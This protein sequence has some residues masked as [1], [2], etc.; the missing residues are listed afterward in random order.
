MLQPNDPD[1]VKTFADLVVERVMSAIDMAA[2]P[3]P[4]G[5]TANAKSM[6]KRAVVDH[7]KSQMLDDVRQFNMR[8]AL[9]HYVERCVADQRAKLERQ[10]ERAA[11]SL[12]RYEAK[13]REFLGIDQTA[14]R[15]VASEQAIDRLLPIPAHGGGYEVQQALRSRGLAIAAMCGM[16][17]YGYAQAPETKGTR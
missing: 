15:L 8:T 2:M 11:E 17:H 12:E 16:T 1:F 14:K 6:A 7:I 10:T 13:L 5:A 4:E 9:A 3:M